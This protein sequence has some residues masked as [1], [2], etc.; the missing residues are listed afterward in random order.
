MIEPFSA[1]TLGGLVIDTSKAAVTKWFG[2]RIA[3]GF[4]LER[5]ILGIP[6]KS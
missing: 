4:N 6:R 2:A 1:A 5:R 3:M